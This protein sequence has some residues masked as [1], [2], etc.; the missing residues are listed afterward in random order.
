MSQNCK[1]SCNKCGSTSN[2]RNPENPSCQDSQQDCKY[3][4]SIGECSSN[5]AYMSQNCKASCNKCGSTSNPTNPTPRRRRSNSGS[6]P[7]CQ[8]GQRDCKYWASIGECS[9]NP[10]YMSQNCKA[11]CN[12]CGSSSTPTNPQNPSCQDG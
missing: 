8:D 2:P 9:R 11:A 4:A 5:S 10:A 6:N 1:A 7:G 12:K 3:W